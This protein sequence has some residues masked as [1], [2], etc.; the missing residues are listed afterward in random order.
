MR[1]ALSPVSFSIRS[2]SAI[3][4]TRSVFPAHA[5]ATRLAAAYLLFTVAMVM[6]P[7]ADIPE[8]LLDEANTPANEIVVEKAASSWEHRQLVPAFVPRIFA[9]PRRTT[10]RRISQVHTGRPS[11]SR[12]FR[13]LFCSLIC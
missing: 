3:T 6:V 12:T 13:E 1:A 4:C 8:T 9:Q 2:S 11:D 7:T 10:F 5:R